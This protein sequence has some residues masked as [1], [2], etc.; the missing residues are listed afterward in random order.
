MLAGRFKS[1]D[2]LPADDSR[3]LYPRFQPENFAVN[4]ELVH[5]L[6]SLAKEKQCKATQLALSWIKT[7]AKRRGLPLV[8]P[9]PGATTEERV[10]ENAVEVDLTSQDLDKIDGILAK[11]AVVGDRYPEGWP[12]D[13]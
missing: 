4:L 9:I 2:D 13:G 6:E 3:R 1:L 5:R 10:R 11:F 7:L 12:R 8:I